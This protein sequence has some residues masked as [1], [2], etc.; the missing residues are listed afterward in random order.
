[1]KSAWARSAHYLAISIKKT[2]KS[3][4]WR[5][6]VFS[7]R[8]RPMST[9]DGCAAAAVP[10]ATGVRSRF[11]R[12]YRELY[13]LFIFFL[14]SCWWSLFYWLFQS[15]AHCLH[16]SVRTC[17]A[18]FRCC[19]SIDLYGKGVG[20]KTWKV[21]P[22]ADQSFCCHVDRYDRTSDSTNSVNA[23]LKDSIFRIVKL[24]KIFIWFFC[25]CRC[26]D[27]KNQSK[28]TGSCFFPLESHVRRITFAWL[29][30]KSITSR[31]ADRSKLNGRRDSFT[32]T[33][34]PL[35]NAK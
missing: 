7:R 15:S 27:E 29:T 25:C 9:G 21:H 20:M 5:L 2:E 8:H 18:L 19:L 35:E 32:L 6:T 16:Y 3:L 34:R 22:S 13:R 30:S 1:M 23:N 28:T 26:W 4:V 12:P 31:M 10:I 14:H 17:T 33:G 24:E 11:D